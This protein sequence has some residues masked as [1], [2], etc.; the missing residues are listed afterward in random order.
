MNEYEDTY[1]ADEALLKEALSRFEIVADK[2]SRKQAVDDMRFANVEGAQWDEDS[3][4]KRLNRPRFSINR[5]SGAIA[6]IVGDQRQ[7]KI[8]IKVIPKGNGATKDI[9]KI[10]SGL[11]MNIEADSNA[12]NIYDAAFDESVTCGFG[13]WRV[14]T[15]YVD[16]DVFEQDICV[17]WIPS[18]ASSL[19][20]D[21]SAKEYDKSDANYAFVITT[22]SKD[23]FKSKWPD[24]NLDSFNEKVSNQSNCKDWYS[25]DNV[26]IAEYWKKEP[27]I[28]HIALLS[29]GRVIDQNEEKSVLDELAR[30]GVTVIKTRKVKSYKI[31]MTV[32]SGTQVLEEPKPWAG[33]YIPLIPLYGK[34]SVIEGKEYVKGMVRDAKDPQRIYNYSTSQVIEASALTPKD[35]YWYTPAQVAG[36][37]AKYRNFNRDNSPFMPY[38]PDPAVGGAPPQR[39]GSPSVQQSLIAQVQQAAT[40]I[41]A[42]T[43]IEPASLGNSPE[44]KSGKAIMAQ[45]AMGDR[46]SFVYTDNLQKSIKYTGKVLVDLIPRIKDTEQAVRIMDVSGES[47]EVEINKVVQTVLDEQTGKEQVVND[48]T[49]GKYAVEITSGPSYTTK[50][51]QTADQLVQLAG[52]SP[53]LQ[54]LAMDLIVQNLDINNSEELTKRVRTMMIQQGVVTPTEE[55]VEEMGLNQP[56]QPNPQDIAVLENIQAESAKAIAE[57]QNKQADTVSKQVKAQQEAVKSLELLVDTLKQKSESGIPLTLQDRDLLIKQSDIVA[58]SQ[59]VL[60]QGPNSEEVQDIVNMQ[61]NLQQERDRVSRE[62]Q[63]LIE[64]SI[65]MQ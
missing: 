51:A 6:Q 65:R 4:S 49:A 42:T 41:H 35:P 33:K 20:F 26:R 7:N 50:R 24:A 19:Y 53:V 32:I 47:E 17:E 3:I 34:I 1:S 57:T 31:T 59:Q 2:D 36:H 38:N 16:D 60:S 30:S 45:Q 37:E 8:A 56:Q 63:A 12:A 40:D 9:A 46:G 15:K 39:T 44:L 52:Q 18:A 29:D 10:Y 5:I 22:M 64:S 11:I 28:K 48:I 62:S 58:Q 27:V 54:Q 55:E 61:Q 13:G 43:G 25:G 14:V 21:K 23:E